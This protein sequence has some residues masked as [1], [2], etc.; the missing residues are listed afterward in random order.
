MEAYTSLMGLLLLSRALENVVSVSQLE[1]ITCR[2]KFYESSYLDACSVG[3]HDGVRLF[4]GTLKY[5]TAFRMLL[6]C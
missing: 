5:L 1:Q 3:R 4:L 2:D 6:E